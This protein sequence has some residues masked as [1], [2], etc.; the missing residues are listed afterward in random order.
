MK[1]KKSKRK[2]FL[3]EKIVPDFLVRIVLKEE[4]TKNI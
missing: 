1:D 4:G 3:W 2:E